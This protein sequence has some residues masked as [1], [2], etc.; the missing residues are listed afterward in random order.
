MHFSF[1]LFVLLSLLALCY[2]KAYSF[3]LPKTAFN[4]FPDSSGSI[5]L[6]YLSNGE[7]MAFHIDSSS[8]NGTLQKISISGDL[9]ES[10]LLVDVN[11][12][13]SKLVPLNQGGFV[14]A[15]SNLS[16]IMSFKIY[17]NNM[18]LRAIQTTGSFDVFD[19]VALNNGSFIVAMGRTM[20][21]HY[22]NLIFCDNLTGYT[23]GLVMNISLSAAIYNDLRMM[24]ISNDRVVIIALLT[25]IINN[26]VV[27]YDSAHII[28][29][30]SLEI[31]SEFYIMMYT[32][33]FPNYPVD[34]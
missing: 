31:S 15:Y 5:R 28:N 32:P 34:C 22:L 33:K 21:N 16:G 17:N 10:P 26:Q 6:A 13:S 11:I 25:A 27:F 7:I 24:N 14:V 12:T 3:T 2:S 23:L 19:R 4:I 18:T 29:C 30:S 8:R 20:I 1:C 9:I